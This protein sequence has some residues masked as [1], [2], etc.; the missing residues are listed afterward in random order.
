MLT[1][2]DPLYRETRTRRIKIWA[3]SYLTIVLLVVALGFV[4]YK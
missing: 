1:N 2:Y 3:A 4:F